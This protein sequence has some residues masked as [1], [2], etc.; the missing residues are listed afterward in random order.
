MAKAWLEKDE[1]EGVE[2][3]EVKITIMLVFID[4][5]GTNKGSGHA[6]FALVYVVVENYASFEASVKKI[7]SNLGIE[8]FHW[9]K[10]APPV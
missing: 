1:K 6:A 3:G 9:A 5:S 4:E 10:C 2:S 8:Y 7:E